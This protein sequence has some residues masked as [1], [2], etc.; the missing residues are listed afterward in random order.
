MPSPPPETVPP[1][2]KVLRLPT[3]VRH[4]VLAMA[5]LLASITYL[6]RVAISV[7]AADMRADL[8][9]SVVQMSWVFSAF[10]LSYGLFEIP[11]GW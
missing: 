4:K 8:G 2:T 1:P 7:T 10:V 11:T 5:M 3:R 6:D 9:L